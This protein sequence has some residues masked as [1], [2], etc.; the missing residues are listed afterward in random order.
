MTR[1]YIE[2][3]E[4]YCCE[5]EA[6]QEDTEHDYAS[7]EEPPAPTYEPP[8]DDEDTGVEYAVLRIGVTTLVISSD[9]RIRKARDLFAS[10]M[11]YAYP[12]TPYR[13]YVVE[14]EKDK[15]EEYFVHDLVWRAFY[16]EPPEGWEVRHTLW[17][18]KKGQEFYDN[19]LETLQ[20]YPS[21]VAYLPSIQKSLPKAG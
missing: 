18:A 1:R 7:E 8:V 15:M 2:E 17:E 13:T 4:D 20:I 6:L 21:T 5:Q 11:G 14:V 3:E 12:G 16:G 9:G 10:S 19:S